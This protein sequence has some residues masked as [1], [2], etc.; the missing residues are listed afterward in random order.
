M[1]VGDKIRGI[2][3]LKG[4]S[5]ENMADLLSLSVRAYG[6]IE[7]GETDVHF[8]RL[9]QIADK[10]GVSVSD[11]LGFGDRVSNFFDQC[12]NPNVA[13]V[14]NGSSQNNYY[15]AR[16]LQHQVE[17]LAIENKLLK[18]EKDKAELEVKYLKEKYSR[19]E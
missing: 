6:D 7:R 18:S 16:E 1:K 19:E 12:T 11:V 14:T 5:Q 13:T 8:S 17:K 9:E 4:L 2:R 15:D 10:L 3:Q